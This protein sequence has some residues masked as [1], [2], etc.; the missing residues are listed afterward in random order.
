MYEHLKYIYNVNL[1]KF[2]Y[3]IQYNGILWR[4]KNLQSCKWP[5]INECFTKI[6]SIK[7]SVKANGK[8]VY[9]CICWNR[10]QESK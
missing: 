1:H 8:W 6:L 9:K 2:I 5:A 4:Q 7:Q 10:K 3:F